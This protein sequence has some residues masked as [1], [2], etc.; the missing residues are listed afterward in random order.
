M[1]TD[2]EISVIDGV[3]Q[4]ALNAGPSARMNVQVLTALTSALDQ[5]AEDG[6]VR[7]IVIRGKGPVFPSGITDPQGGGDDTAN[8]LAKVCLQIE[9]FAKPVITVLT[10]PV[11]GAGVEIALASHYRLVHHQTRIGF[12]HARLGLVPR[13]GATQRMPRLVGAGPTL[14]VLIGGALVPVSS[15]ALRGLADD[16]FDDTPDAAIARFVTELGTKGAAPRPTADLRIGFADATAY[17]TALTRVRDSIDAS[18]EVAPRKILAATEAALLLP[19][20]AGL[21]FEDAAAE[22]CADTEQSKALSHVFHAEQVVSAQVRR[23]DLPEITTIGVLGGSAAARQIVLAAL[24][25]RIAVNWLIKNPDQQHDSLA[26]IKTVLQQSAQTGRIS[27]EIVTWARQNLRSSDNA[28]ILTGS[29]IVLRATRGQRGVAIPADT[30]VAH[31]LPGSDP[32]LAMQFAEPASSSRLVEVVLGPHAT[33]D[34]R[35]I[36]LALARCLNKLALVETTSDLPLFDRLTQTLWRASDALVDLGQSPFTIDAAMHD[37]GMVLPP[38]RLADRLGL[39]LVSRQHRAEGCANWS[40][41]LIQNGRQGLVNR[42]G[43]YRYAPEAEP[44][45]DQEILHKIM[46]RRA[47]QANMAPEDIRCC[48]IGSMANTGAKALR[49]GTV[50]RA[51]D[52]DVLSVFTH[53]VPAWRGGVMHAAGDAGLLKTTRL[54]QALGHPD[55]DLWSPEPIF[56]ELIKYGRTFDDL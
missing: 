47:P 53:L 4:I 15:D 49:D 6:A 10:G 34:D 33:T 22:D 11:V 18:P 16:L 45:A 23:N 51:G 30:P 54:M 52:I 24:E 43:F 50:A 39:D 46:E 8:L 55:Q 25:A 1:G 56:S 38:Y 28:E 26:H 12:P 27:R 41:L 3:A 7:I 36:G 17:H 21:A 2:T 35:R 14:D 44:D 13:A 29:N 42:Q 48:L 9:R 5:L 37:W 32:R 20:D 31:C 40:E 19:I